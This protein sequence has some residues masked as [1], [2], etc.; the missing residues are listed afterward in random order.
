MTPVRYRHRVVSVRAD[1]VRRLEGPEA[2]KNVPR[3]TLGRD[4]RIRPWS[5]LV[6]TREGP[7]ASYQLVLHLPLNRGP[8]AGAITPPERQVIRVGAENLCHLGKCLADGDRLDLAL[9][10]GRPGPGLA[11]GGMIFGLW[12]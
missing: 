4:G 3:R 10:V 2:Y 5:P 1:G 12:A 9:D 7:A 6:S 11:G 8:T